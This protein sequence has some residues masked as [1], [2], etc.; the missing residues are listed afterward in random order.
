VQPLTSH[1][2]RKQIAKSGNSAVW[3]K[4]GKE[5]VYSDQPG[6]WS[7]PVGGLGTDLR[8]AAPAPLF[9]V[10]RPFGLTSASRPLAISRD[11]SR[12]YFLQ[13]AEEPNAEVLHV[14]TGAIR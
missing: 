10:S 11:G 13:S 8:F 14:R 6:I 1:G 2:L 12:I 9:S 3:R 5:I 4:D 7:V